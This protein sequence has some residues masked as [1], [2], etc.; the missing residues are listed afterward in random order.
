MIGSKR[1]IVVQIRQIFTLGLFGAEILRSGMIT[2]VFYLKV[3]DFGVVIRLNYLFSLGVFAVLN[4]YVFIILIGLVLDR[5]D[6]P[7]K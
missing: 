2:K 1:H 3:A 7:F 4:N 5:L 6:T